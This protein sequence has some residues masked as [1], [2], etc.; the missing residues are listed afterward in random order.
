M[1]NKLIISLILIFILKQQLCMNN[2]RNFAKYFMKS[3]KYKEIYNVLSEMPDKFKEEGMSK[4]QV[5]FYEKYFDILPYLKIKDEKFKKIYLK[6]MS[7]FTEEQINEYMNS[8]IYD[9]K[10]TRNLTLI[11]FFMLCANFV[12]SQKR[13]NDAEKRYE[14]YQKDMMNKF[15]RNNITE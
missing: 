9:E 5:F 6:D 8:N 1:K 14:I 2:L 10:L 7:S 11:C 15:K 13:F 12:I 3:K 4:S